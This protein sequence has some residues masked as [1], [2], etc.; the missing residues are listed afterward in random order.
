MLVR[1]IFSPTRCCNLAE[2]V[3]HKQTGDVSQKNLFRHPEAGIGLRIPPSQRRIA[4]FDRKLGHPA[5]FGMRCRARSIF[6]G[7][8]PTHLVPECECK[9]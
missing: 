2:D 4:H 8:R 6:P 3:A 1:R 9:N 7:R 5:E